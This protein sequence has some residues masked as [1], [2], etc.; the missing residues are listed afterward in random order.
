L[1]Q[2]ILNASQFA[3]SDSRIEIEA[4]FVKDASMLPDSTPANIILPCVLVTVTDQG[5]GLN[6]DELETV[7]LPF[8][9]TDAARMYQLPGAGLGL[10]LARSIMILQGGNLWAEA[11]QPGQFG[12]RLSFT[13]PVERF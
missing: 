12:G 3:P 8:F 9:R 11:R 2:L 4:R 1:N 10:A 7:F 6:P 13:V 5:E